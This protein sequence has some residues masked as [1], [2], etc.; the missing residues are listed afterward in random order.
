M[1]VSKH[2][3]EVVL[4]RP[5]IRDCL[6]HGVINY[7]ALSRLI[8]ED[9]NNMGIRASVG[10]IKMALI[11]FSSDIRRKGKIE[12]RI[13]R[14]IAESVLELQTDLGVITVR[15]S[16]V[17][18]RI[19]DLIGLMERARF[20]QMTQGLDTF[21]I[22]VA[23]ELLPRILSIFPK[24]LI[25]STLS[26]QTALVMVSPEDIVVTPGVLELVLYT[27]SSN[28]IN[29]T[30]VISCYK[31]T[32]LIFDRSDASTAYKLLEDLILTT[33]RSLRP[34]GH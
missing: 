25:V 10:A 2:V 30:Q 11:R 13:R 7:S 16:A 24:R 33:R 21:S 3:R 6:A 27:L 31:D 23:S 1:S 28:G 34:S 15:R 22:V 8:Q 29:V 19:D 32:V 20:F 18:Q 17:E 26:D 4:T 12:E 5:A 9:L 14:V